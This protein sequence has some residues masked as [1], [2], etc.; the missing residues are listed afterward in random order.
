MRFNKTQKRLRAEY[1]YHISSGHERACISCRWR[2]ESTGH[3]E[4]IQQATDKV[5]V[6]IAWRPQ[7]EGK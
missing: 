5:A 7:S 1:E 3:C 4:V 2:R 6:C